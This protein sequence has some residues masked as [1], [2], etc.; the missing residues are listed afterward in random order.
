MKKLL[1]FLICL[2]LGLGIINNIKAETKY[3]KYIIEENKAYYV[4]KFDIKTLIEDV[5]VSTFED[6]G[7]NFAK[8]KNQVYGGWSNY[9]VGI[10]KG[11]DDV[12]L[13]ELTVIH[14]HFM[15]DDKNI[16]Y[17]VCDYY[18]GHNC[19]ATKLDV[20]YDSFEVCG[21]WYIVKDKNGVYT[22]KTTQE[23]SSKLVELNLDPDTLVVYDKYFIKD[24]DKV[25]YGASAN[26]INSWS[27]TYTDIEGADSESFEVI[28]G[29]ISKDKN[30]GYCGTGKLKNSDSD[31]IEYLSNIFVKDKNHVWN[32][33]RNNSVGILIEGADAETFKALGSQYAKD[34]NKVYYESCWNYYCGVIETGIDPN[35]V[36]F[37]SDA[38]LKDKNGFYI[39]GSRLGVD[40][41]G[42][43]IDSFVYINDYNIKDKN[44][45]Y[46]IQYYRGGGTILN[47][48]EGEEYACSIPEERTVIEGDYSK[49]DW[50][51]CLQESVINGAN[52][53]T[54]EAIQFPYSKDDDQIFYFWD[55]IPTEVDMGSFQ[56]L[57]NDYSRDKNA[58]FYKNTIVNDADPDSFKLN[59]NDDYQ[60]EDDN[61]YFDK[62][63]FLRAKKSIDVEVSEDN[64]L[65][66]RLK[67]KI[68]LKVEDV[69][70]AYYLNLRT[71]T[72]HYLGRP[73]DAFNVMREQG[74][75]ISEVTYDKFNGY[76]SS[77][78]SGMILL[79]VEAN[80]EA[81]YVDPV[82]LKMH[83]LG[84]P[85]DAYNVMRNLGLG[86]SNSDFERLIK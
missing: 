30:Y 14:E 68:I 6:I 49:T 28:D 26:D 3:A 39:G 57:D 75:G 63:K 24:K 65:F 8:D 58:I 42:I 64:S 4:S 81:Y 83:Y 10:F 32:C 1:I 45:T 27:D 40:G 54:F 77:N 71:N 41:V 16:F 70:R 82:D 31:T 44:G 51:T 5:D 37:V 69:G 11:F 47:R 34:K 85:I 48:I 2:L 9:Y 25:F 84:R 46:N 52:P 67:G 60:A 80:G 72:S 20:D 21:D 76:A 53:N 35:T 13:M 33:D 78:L 15:K 66:S 18:D 22:S 56:I 59:Y 79:R 19:Y 61:Y 12:N 7:F 73:A 23:D 62:G 29:K 50:S 36:E 38:I 43:D 86:I 17:V 74:L 55:P